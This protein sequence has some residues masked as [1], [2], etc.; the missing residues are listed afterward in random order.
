MDDGRRRFEQPRCSGDRRARPMRW[1]RR[2]RLSVVLVVH[3]MP[4]EAPRTLYSLTADYQRGV[5][6]RDYEV[7]V[8]DNGSR[9]P[10][11]PEPRR[12]NLRYFYVENARP[13]P[14]A[15]MNF[16]ARRARGRHLGLLIDGARIATPGLLH[17]ALRAFAAFGDPV[18]TAPAWHIGP[19]IHSRA[20]AHLG[21]SQ[22]AE[23]ALLERIRWTEDGYRLFEVSTL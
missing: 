5:D 2:P 8:V 12:D 16:G 11:S 23:D 17:Y 7:I 3:D 15:A 13:S 1:R 18:V 14:M 21:H 22:A 6:A 10:Y 19:D 4:R 20:I 9:P